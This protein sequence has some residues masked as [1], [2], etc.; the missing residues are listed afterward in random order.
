MSL[1]HLFTQARSLS[2]GAAA[3]KGTVL[4]GRQVGARLRAA[5]VKTR[6]TY[7]DPAPEIRI[8]GGETFLPLPSAD[9]RSRA[10]ARHYQAHRFNILGSGW[11]HVI[12]GMSCPGF[13]GAA[14]TMPGPRALSPGN[15]QRAA[16]IR[17]AISPGYEPIDWQLDFRS[18]YRW[19][20]DRWSETLLL[21]HEPGVDVKVPW[22]LARL[23]HLPLLATI[24]RDDTNIARECR[25]QIL[26]F[27]AANPPGFGVNW[28]CTMDVAIRAA[29]LVLCRWIIGPGDEIFEEYFA[30]TLLAHGRHIVTNLEDTEGFRGN[31]YLADVCG[32]A[33]VAAA[34]SESEETLGWW[35]FAIGEVLAESAR[36]F[37]PDGT[38]FEASTSYHRLS[39]EMVA[40]TAALILGRDGVGA[41]PAGFAERLYRM[42]RFSID[43]TKPNGRV[44]QIGDNDS[45]RFFK[46]SAAHFDADLE[47]DHLD[48]RGLVAAIGTIIAG[49]DDLAAFSGP[50]FAFETELV[51]ALASGRRLQPATAPTAPASVPLKE[52]SVSIAENQTETT[53]MLHDASVL[54]GLSAIAYPD[55][56]LY[57]LTAPRF[58]LSIRCGSIGQNGRGGHAH[59]DQLAVELN[60]D[61]EDW[62]A[63]PGSYVYTAAPR[64]R[65]AY[66]SVL[67]HATPKHDGKEPGRLDL[68]LFR[69]GDEARA[70]CLG[71]SIEGF[72][73]RHHGFGLPTYRAIRIADGLVRIRDGIGGAVDWATNVET[74]TVT[75]TH[76]LRRH[77]GLS[78]PFSPGYGSLGGE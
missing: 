42:A 47:E 43:A 65:D 53:I 2:F 21:G 46:L 17:A 72:E 20:E 4:I 37:H 3:R 74:V 56:G 28:L 1:R 51:G 67:A 76:E 11:V 58:F 10:L 19:K 29:N 62:L 24:G 25:D 71:F 55:F 9:A 26:D 69:L 77:F 57:I 73:G 49:A 6:C 45:G 63:D 48:H 40:Y 50:A 18:G 54:D 52:T 34:L 14:Y 36:Q 59:N 30:A 61:G 66:R 7:V 23:Q 75:T 78:V 32:L 33:F 39:A 38:N 12:H 70:E 8:G 15:R 60:I 22:E 35:R 13:A 27:L 31:H 41:F 44:A 68:G 5:A 64:Q 16:E